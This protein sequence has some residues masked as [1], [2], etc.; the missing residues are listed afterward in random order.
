LGD[1]NTRADKNDWSQVNCSKEMVGASVAI[2]SRQIICQKI[3]RMGCLEE[4]CLKKGKRSGGNSGGIHDTDQDMGNEAVIK[5]L[6]WIEEGESSKLVEKGEVFGMKGPLELRTILFQ[7]GEDDPNG[8]KLNSDLKQAR[9]FVTKHDEVARDQDG[10]GCGEA[11]WVTYHLFYEAW[12]Y[13][14]WRDKTDGS[15]KMVHGDVEVARI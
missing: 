11:I 14:K 3:A 12:K 7:E 8:V 15:D 2:H 6:G 1:K 10:L 9:E 5:K 4:F 13:F